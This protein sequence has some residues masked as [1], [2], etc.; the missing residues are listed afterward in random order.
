VHGRD[1]SD[2]LLV[3]RRELADVLV[4]AVFQRHAARRWRWWRWWRGR[5]VRGSV[6]RG[7]G[8]RCARG[9]YLLHAVVRNLP[10]YTACVR[11]L[12]DGVPSA[13]FT[14]RTLPPPVAV[15]DRSEIIRQHSRRQY[16]RPTKE[17]LGR[18]E[19]ELA[20]S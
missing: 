6:R 11:L 12:I 18:V 16:A 5:S 4:V 20:S 10:K 15:E 3:D 7:R 19:R 8:G 1:V 17:V 9:Q 13:P 2:E 14:L